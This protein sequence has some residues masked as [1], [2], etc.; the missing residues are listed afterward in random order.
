MGSLLDLLY[1]SNCVVCGVAPSPLCQFCQRPAE[2]R[3]SSVAGLKLRYSQNLDS[4]LLQIM[5]AFKDRKLVALSGYLA[6][7]LDAAMEKAQ[8]EY[9]AVPPTN[10]SNF[11]KRGFHPIQHLVDRSSILGSKTQV[12]PQTIRQVRDQ[13]ELNRADR[14]ANLRGSLAFPAGSGQL[15]IVDDVVTTGATV[16]EMARAAR[17]AGYQPMGICAIAYSSTHQ[18]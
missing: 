3:Q 11:R 8:F 10:R 14:A 2:A 5:R 13:R 18:F 4:E 15:L 17:A 9:F 6:N 16:D 1:P 12:R 7:Q